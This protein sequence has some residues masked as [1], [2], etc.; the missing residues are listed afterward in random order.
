MVPARPEPLGR[1]RDGRRGPPEADGA[2]RLRDDARAAA[3]PPRQPRRRDPLRRPGGR[4]D[5]GRQRPRPGAADHRRAAATQPRMAARAVHRPR[6]RCSRPAL[7]GH[8]AALARVRHLGLHQRAR[9]GSGRST[10]STGVTRSSRCA[11]PIRAR[12]TCPTSGRYHRGCRDR[13]AALRRHRRSGV[14][15]A[16]RGGRRASARRP[17]RDAFRRAGVEAVSL[18]TDEDLVRAIVRMATRR[19][20]RRK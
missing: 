4:D 6:R 14:P 15:A 17:S 19:R 3:D 7:N 2:G 16:L 12:A 13:R 18:S 8:Q 10:C 11:S 20:R 9:A 5:P 1:L